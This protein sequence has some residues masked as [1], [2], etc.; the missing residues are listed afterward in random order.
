MFGIGGQKVGFGAQQANMRRQNWCKN[1][2]ILQSCPRSNVTKKWGLNY[3]NEFKE[4]GNQQIPGA[5][6][7]PKV[8]EAMSKSQM[9]WRCLRFPVKRV[10]NWH[11]WTVGEF[12]LQVGVKWA[13]S[14]LR[15]KACLWNS[16]H[17]LSSS[18][19]VRWASCGGACPLLKLWARKQEPVPH[20]GSKFKF[21]PQHLQ[22]TEQ[23]VGKHSA[24]GGLTVQ[25]G[26]SEMSTR[27]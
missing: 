5:K 23:T 8:R 4:K 6:R 16:T 14:E 22:I 26:S 19:S 2:S 17:E 9:G 18:P 21:S 24:G 11:L 7:E 13:N 3:T 15:K 25:L 1:S 27:H 20:T 10:W 12:T